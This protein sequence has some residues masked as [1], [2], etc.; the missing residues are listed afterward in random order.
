LTKA[1]MYSPKDYWTE[2]A[3]SFDSADVSGLAPILHPGAP[4]WFNQVIDNVQLRAV[5]RALS[6]A[7]IPPGARFLDVGCGT[8]RWMRRYRDLGF[9]PVGVDATIGML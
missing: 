3:Q 9:S 6:T 4:G 7:S 2:L 8:G 5:R 1:E